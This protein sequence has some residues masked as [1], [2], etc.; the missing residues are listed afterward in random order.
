MRGAETASR[1]LGLLAQAVPAFC[2][3]LVVIWIVGVELRWIRPFT[4]GAF[5]RVVLPLIVVAL[6]AAGA[7]VRVAAH[8]ITAA[9]ATPWFRAVLAKG[10]SPRL[11]LR[12]HGGRFG[13]LALLAALRAEAAWVIGGT[14]V[15]E[16]VFASPGVSAW[17]V[18]SIAQR[19]YPVLQAYI[20]T[21]A[22]WMVLVRFTV[23]QLALW[24]D[25]R[26]EA[27]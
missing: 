9:A 6:Y 4:G 27:S 7:L 13:I 21:V 10:L 23:D 3:A 16:V 8:A 18:E 11:A 25:P 17:V 15:I 26:R 14:A 2:L 12:R 1:A 20:L 19:D 22:V 5:E 24:L